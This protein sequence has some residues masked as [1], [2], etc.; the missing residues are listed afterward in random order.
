MSGGRL[1]LGKME[2]QTGKGGME[3][4]CLRSPIIGVFG[5]G[6]IDMSAES[7]PIE[8]T[9]DTS[10]PEAASS[11]PVAEKIVSPSAEP[12]MAESQPPSSDE[13]KLEE[14]KVVPTDVV[15]APL[16]STTS[17]SPSAEVPAVAEPKVAE[18]TQV[19]LAAYVVPLQSLVAFH[20][21]EMANMKQLI[22]RW[23]SE[24]GRTTQRQQDLEQDLKSKNQKVEELLKLN[25]KAGKKEANGLKKEI[26]KIKKEIQSVVK[27]LTAKRK[28]LSAEIQT[29]SRDSQKGVKE[30]CEQ[31]ISEIKKTK[32]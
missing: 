28:E 31:V 32:N 26:S 14:E 10:M 22:A 30:V 18:K 3:K 23:D 5:Y 29:L 27:E 1:I 17:V 2:F 12:A 11:T 9:V 13:V 20:E 7:S 19:K 21:K 16:I 4:A 6:F 24:I 25:T 8:N 15:T